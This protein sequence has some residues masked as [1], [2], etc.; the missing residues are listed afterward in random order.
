MHIT[1]GTQS[2]NAVRCLTSR[3]SE[4]CRSPWTSQS[5]SPWKPS[6]S[7]VPDRTGRTD[8]CCSI[9]LPSIRLSEPHAQHRR[10]LPLPVMRNP[11]CLPHSPDILRGCLQLIPAY[12]LQWYCL[13]LHPWRT[14]WH[15]AHCLRRSPHWLLLSIPHRMSVNCLRSLCSH[16]AP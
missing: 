8:P 13:R 11:V 4:W 3:Q 12:P 10:C 7:E 14:G 15:P 6:L 16:T 5:L 1:S 2:S 9:S